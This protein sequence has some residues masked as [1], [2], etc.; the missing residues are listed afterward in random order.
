MRSIKSHLTTSLLLCLLLPTCLI[1]GT[2]Y[3]FVFNVIKENRIGTVGQLADTRHEALRIRLHEDLQRSKD[4]LDTLIATCRSNNMTINACA[5]SRL[6]QFADVNHAVGLTFHS[7]TEPDL[8][9]GSEAIP[10]AS[11]LNSFQPD[12]LSTIS[13]ARLTGDWLYSVIATDVASG[14]RLVSTY[15]AQKLEK[16]FAQTPLLGHSGETF[17]ANSQGL[18][19]TKPRYPSEQGISKTISAMPMQRCLLKENSEMLDLD[20]RNVPIIHG[21]RFVPEIGGG[22]IM[23]HI[24]QTEAFMPLRRLTQELILLFGLGTFAAWLLATRLGENLANPILTLAKMVQLFSKG[25][26]TQRAPANVITEIDQLSHLFNDMAGQLDA[27]LSK[28]KKSEHQL[29]NKVAERTAELQ[30]RNKKYRSVIQTTGDGFWRVN[31][32]GYLLEVN[33]AYER[34]SGYSEHELIGLRITNLEA[35][36]SPEETA[37][38]IQKIMQQGSDTFETRHRRKDGSVWDTEVITSFISDEGGYF[39][40]F[41]RD[42]TERKRTEQELLIAAS[43]FETQEGIMITDTNGNIVRVNRAFTRIT[44]YSSD[45]AIGKNAS[46]LRSGRHDQDFY[47]VIHQALQTASAWEGEIWD[48]HKDGHIYPQWLAMTAVKDTKG[49]ISHYISNFSDITERKASEEKIKSLAFYDTL[50]NLPN[51]RLLI[52]RL[53]HAITINTRTGDYGALLFLDLD[54]F[55]LLNDTQGHGMGDELLIEV[56][57]RLKVCVRK[58]DTVARLGGDEFIVLMEKFDQASEQIALQ[59]KTVAEKIV[60][61]LASP[62]SLSKVIHHS[63]SSIGIV[64][65]NGSDI[66]ADT[67]LSQADTAMYAAKKSGKNAYRFFDQIMQRELDQRAKL[68]FDLKMA[69]E[70]NQLKLFF[71]PQLDVQGKTVGFEAHIRWNH[72]ELGM[73][74]AEQFISIAD[75]TGIILAIGQWALKAACDQLSTW[76]N[77]PLMREMSIAVN[78]SGKQ[79]YQASFTEALRALIAERAIDAS[80]LKL[81]LTERMIL[82]KIDSTIGKMLDLKALGVM[83]VMDDFGTGYSSL[84]LLRAIPFDQVKIDKSFVDRFKENSTDAFLISTILT[85][86]ELVGI[87]VIADGVENNEQYDLLKSMGCSVFQGYFLGQPEPIETI[88]YQLL[89][90]STS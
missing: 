34:L 66:T 9:F 12:Q 57:R 56:A 58:A 39:V 62:Y 60:T 2:A 78:I 42:I 63:S 11:L 85:L 15:P 5:Q 27:A 73:I 68:E 25:D 89:I 20:Y 50:T 52:E 28:L 6:K 35:Q 17:L 71:Q 43:A 36:E 82:E 30:D 7:G 23:A 38:H 53:E 37:A 69:V 87:D 40:A 79:F 3:W 10:L 75:E 14:F 46:I 88:E 64:L 44:G 47:S 59:V 74:P 26:F 49:N 80:H 45:D 21:F 90:A 76:K 8:A 83:L 16:L 54:N 48:H 41:F 33:P 13:T 65:F 51:R 24:D 55:K 72:P 70:N 77:Q 4:L 84:S 18:F 32:N 81:E 1:G 67:V 19:I 22:C 86:G 29:E 61:A 31:T